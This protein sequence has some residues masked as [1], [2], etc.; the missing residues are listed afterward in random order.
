MY[1]PFLLHYNVSLGTLLHQLQ[2]E[3]FGVTIHAMLISVIDPCSSELDTSTT[4]GQWSAI[5]LSS[6]TI[7]RL[8]N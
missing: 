5:S 7:P 3:S 2:S 1:P 4:G 8:Q 6:N